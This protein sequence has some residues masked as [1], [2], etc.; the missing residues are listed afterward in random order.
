MSK[1]VVIGS[2]GSKL[3][4][5]QAEWV[6]AKLRELNP[7]VEFSLVRITTQG[8]RDR[9]VPLDQMP[10]VGVFVK[11]LEEALLDR[12]IDL[13][14]HSLKDMPVNL[15]PGLKLAAVPP[16]LDPRDALVCRKGR[17]TEMPPGSRIGTGS[18]RRYV[19]LLSCRPELEVR[20]IRGNVD[21]RLRKVSSGE[22]DG[23][24]IAAAA[25]IRL[26]WEDKITD[27]LAPEQFLPAVGQ[28]ALGIEIRAGDESIAQFATS[29]DH[30]NTWCCT[31]AERAFLRSLGGGCRAPI[32][33]MGTVAG[34]TLNLE[35]MAADPSGQRI[36]RHSEQGSA[37]DP[38][39]VGE[40]LARQM[41]EMGA[42]EFIGQ[43]GLQ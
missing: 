23:V 7:E 36:L 24:I 29:L 42:S 33:A 15:P 37:S 26:G 28:G 16:R 10:G 38:E 22:F 39:E 40:R 31:M 3:A 2:R 11:E 12:R 5:V 20:N 34:R 19:Q 41:L 6:S 4:L 1:S 35:G 8:D 14:V 17:L 25:L 30:Q 13:A 9:E 32:A 43:G 27:Y 21:T 18:L